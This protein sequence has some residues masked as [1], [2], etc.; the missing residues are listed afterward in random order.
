M[1]FIAPDILFDNACNTQE[2][3]FNRDP[4]FFDV[5]V[6]WAGNVGP[7]QLLWLRH[8]PAPELTPPC[9]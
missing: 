7:R 8:L 3:A 1:L 9:I 4:V 5:E 6:A 2:Y